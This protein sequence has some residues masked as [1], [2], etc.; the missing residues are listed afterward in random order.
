MSMTIAELRPALLV[1]MLKAHNDNPDYEFDLID[2]V[3]LKYNLDAKRRSVELC[4]EEFRDQ[5]LIKIEELPGTENESYYHC[6]MTAEGIDRAEQ[7]AASQPHAPNEQSDGMIAK[8]LTVEG[9]ISTS[10]PSASTTPS[11][12]TFGFA[13]DGAP[14]GSGTFA[15]SD[16][17]VQAN[18][19]QASNRYVSVKDNQPGFD[20]LVTQLSAIKDQYARDHNHLAAEP[21]ANEM[22]AEINAIL[23][24]IEIGV[25]RLGQIAQGLLPSFE[26]TCLMLAAYPGFVQLVH[27][28]I[29]A[30][31]AILTSFGFPL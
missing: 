7:L 20:E 8:G 6:S 22:L 25:V 16:R 14:F 29:P 11:S 24:Q 21:V 26:N 19:I 15:S 28:A 30:I 18:N 1:A 27:D 4:A 17:A 23:A 2:D 10:P 31:N 12:T 3:F 13:P 9:S 5:G